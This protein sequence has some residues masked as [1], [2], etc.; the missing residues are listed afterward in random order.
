MRRIASLTSAMALILAATT[1]FAL[2]QE[3][4][5]KRRLDRMKQA[6]SE[7]RTEE[8]QRQ[9]QIQEATAGVESG[10]SRQS[11]ETLTMPDPVRQPHPEPKSGLFGQKPQP[12]SP[13]ATPSP[14]PVPSSAQSAGPTKALP[15]P[16]APAPLPQPVQSSPAPTAPPAMVQSPPAATAPPAM[17]QAAPLAPAQP[18]PAAAQPGRRDPATAT[19]LAAQAAKAQAAGDTKTALTMLDE[20]IAADPEDPDL[21]NNRGNLLSNAG[22]PREAMADY[23]RAIAA[24]TTDPAFFSNRGLAHERLGNR[25]RACADYKKACDL[26]DCDFFKS[27]KAEG[28]CR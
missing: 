6:D 12:A 9:E 7:I 1:A 26:G 23:D 5:L 10:P 15:A 11:T 25:D 4:I 13:A 21:R 24:K 28:N 18:A 19:A 22:K 17:V 27:Y 16:M 8:R 20:A 14:Q 2:T 3:E